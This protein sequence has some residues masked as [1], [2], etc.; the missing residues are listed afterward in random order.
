MLKQAQSCRVMER[1]NIE[2][3]DFNP[4][5]FGKISKKDEKRQRPSNR[6]CKTKQFPGKTLRHSKAQSELSLR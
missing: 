3:H 5:R 6:N 4:R 1:F 2:A